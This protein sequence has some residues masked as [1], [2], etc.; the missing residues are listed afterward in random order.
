MISTHLA[1]EIIE[2]TE[3][4]ATLRKFLNTPVSSNAGIS[5]CIVQEYG[6]YHEDSTNITIS[7]DYVEIKS[8]V[9]LLIETVRNHVTTLNNMA[10]KEAQAL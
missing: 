3:Q 8:V 10:V 5:L 7:R 9:D 1:K 2:K 6:K 4:L